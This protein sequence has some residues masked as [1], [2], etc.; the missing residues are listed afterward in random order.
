M[1]KIATTTATLLAGAAMATILILACGDDSPS[2]ADAASACDCPAAE[3]PLAGRIV[4]V[5]KTTNPGTEPYLD[6]SAWCES[7]VGAADWILLGGGC[8]VDDGN[9][10]DL[11]LE[12]AGP[13]T[14]ITDTVGGNYFCRWHNTTG[15]T[16]DAVRARAICLVPATE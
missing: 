2:E 10:D 5:D 9:V 15:V 4:F 8:T 11:V 7:A 12:H 13:S 14:V 6:A 16:I 1:Y 3:A